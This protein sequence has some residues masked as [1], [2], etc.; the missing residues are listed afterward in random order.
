MG[1][2]QVSHIGGVY[3]AVRHHGPGD[4]V[5]LG[6]ELGVLPVPAVGVWGQPAAHKPG[7]RGVVDVVHRAA[8]AEDV[9]RVED[10]VLIQVEVVFR[11]ELPQ[12]LRAQVGLLLTEGV[13]QV[14]AV[15]GKL[16]RRDG[17]HVVGDLAGHPVVAA[18]GLK[19]PDLVFVIDGDA[20][21]LIGAVL[22]QKLRKALHAL[23]R[24]MDIGQD[25]QDDVFLPDAAGNLLLA[26]GFGLLVNN[27]RIG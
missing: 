5:A 3:L 26:A 13:L 20:V 10:A 16:V 7:T 14:E 27:Q 25:E 11:D 9:P 24:G 1:G 15:H 19:P 18:D 6:G 2:E 22:L 4:V 17:D 21:G 12:I 23:A 8:G